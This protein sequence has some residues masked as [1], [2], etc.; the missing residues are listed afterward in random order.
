[1][2]TEQEM[3]IQVYRVRGLYQ[4]VQREPMKRKDSSFWKENQ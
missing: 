1:M 2:P 4:D 3:D